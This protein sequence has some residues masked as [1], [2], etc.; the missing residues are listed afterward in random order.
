MLVASFTLAL[1]FAC[2]GRT[3]SEGGDAASESESETTETSETETETS[4]TST[5]TGEPLVPCA[6]ITD[7]CTTYDHCVPSRVVEAYLEGEPGE[8]YY[9]CSDILSTLA[10]L[11]LGCEEIESPFVVICEGGDPMTA[12]GLFEGCI[13][14]GWDVCTL[15]PDC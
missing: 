3:V 6:E 15:D 14:P 2:G 12:R 4:E 13:P 8:E 1:A 7:L 11:D 5:E 9:Y 10:C